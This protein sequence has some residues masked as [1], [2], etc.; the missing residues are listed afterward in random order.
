MTIVGAASRDD[1]VVAVVLDGVVAIL[2]GGRTKAFPV[3]TE[4]MAA[5][6]KAHVRNM[7]LERG[8]GVDIP[9]RLWQDAGTSRTL[10]RSEVCGAFTQ[11]IAQSQLFRDDAHSG[12]AS[13][14]VSVSKVHK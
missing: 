6:A 11:C 13:A 2:F 1:V 14:A 12:V 7:L 3:V 10:V 4:R 9:C 8:V 5:V